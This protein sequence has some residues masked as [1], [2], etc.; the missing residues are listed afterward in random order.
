MTSLR[1][2][3][4]IMAPHGSSSQQQGTRRYMDKPF[5]SSWLTLREGFDAQARSRPLAQAFARLLPVEPNLVDL[6]A[7][8]GSLFRWLAPIIGRPQHWLWLDDDVDLMEEGLRTT[9]SWARRLGYVVQH[10]ECEASLTLETPRGA[11]CIELAGHDLTYPPSLLPLDNADAVTCSAL[12]DLFSED[13][14]DEM[15]HA[16][17]RRPFYAAIN[18]MGNWRLRPCRLSDRLVARG[19]L[20]DQ[21]GNATPM[22]PLGPDVPKVAED[23]CK[24]LGQDYR[25]ARSDWTIQPRQR[26]MLHAMLTFLANAARE[27][28]P[29]RRREIAAWERVRRDDVKA[30]R[31]AMRIGHCDFLVS[32]DPKLAKAAPEQEKQVLDDD[33]ASLRWPPGHESPVE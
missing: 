32:F 22:D 16:I 5:T 7:G 15:L 20:A 4:T 28:M 8:T 19:F 27:A 9:A 6:G 18:V 13:W 25:S 24:E 33:L 17:G 10:D 21:V 26:T 14:L 1:F 11:W 29:G 12:L 31:L 3:E 30:E 2:A 23:I